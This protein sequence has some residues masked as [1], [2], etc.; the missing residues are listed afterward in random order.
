V[1]AVA[2]WSPAA[3]ETARELARQ[4]GRSYVLG[5]VVLEDRRRATI[6]VS[7][8]GRHVLRDRMVGAQLRAVGA[9][10]SV[11][12]WT[13]DLGAAGLRRA[14]TP[15]GISARPPGLAPPHDREVSLGGP[16]AESLVTRQRPVTLTH[17][18]IARAIAHEDGR[19]RT[20]KEDWIDL[21][22]TD[23][24]VTCA[25]R[26]HGS[27]V[28]ET[29]ILD[30]LLQEMADA[31]RAAASPAGGIDGRIP[32]V[33]GA[34]AGGLLFHEIVGHPL[35]GDHIAS[36]SSSNVV[37]CSGTSETFSSELAIASPSFA[38]NADEPEAM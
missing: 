37:P 8:Q 14:L 21:A 35:E 16:W 15:L 32:V 26:W 19:A 1:E 18:S 28:P 11:T 27:A 4:I 31:R 29:F 24:D 30:D 3:L 34:G 6:Q 25:R 17:E 36:G 23:G 13:T 20:T 38:P 33:L 2:R 7:S 12:S 10:R 22:I 5:S 9:R